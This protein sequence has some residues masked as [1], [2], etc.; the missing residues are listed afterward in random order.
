MSAM[1]HAR[2][3][4]FAGQAKRANAEARRRARFVDRS[5]WLGVQA[6]VKEEADEM[7]EGR[8]MTPDQQTAPMIAGPILHA[9]AA[10]Q[11]EKPARRRI[12]S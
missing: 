3:W 10:S 11:G 8:L 7:L 1:E 2:Q 5:A 4:R 9:C 12:L 6:P